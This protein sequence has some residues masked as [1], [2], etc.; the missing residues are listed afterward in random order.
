MPSDQPQLFDQDR[1]ATVRKTKVAIKLQGSAL[2][3]INTLGSSCRRCG[4]QCTVVHRPGKMG[5]CRSFACTC[6]W[7]VVVCT[8]CHDSLDHEPYGEERTTSCGRCGCTKF[9]PT[10]TTN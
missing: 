8:C 7:C 10:P 2:L 4:H 1:M 5:R 9:T 3:N 6:N